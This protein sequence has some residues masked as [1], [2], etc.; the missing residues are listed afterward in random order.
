LDQYDLTEFALKVAINCVYRKKHTYGVD[1]T[2]I[3][4][5]SAGLILIYQRMYQL[6]SNIQF[7]QEAQYWLEQVLTQA[8][9][10]SNTLSGLNAFD[11]KRRQYHQE[12]GLLEGICGV[13]LVLM[14]AGSDVSP[15]WDEVLLLS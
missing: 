10:D 5:G 2:G 7:K 4:H 1:D 15:D 9:K 13:G 12:L 3:C 14:A 11:G 8:E 6:T